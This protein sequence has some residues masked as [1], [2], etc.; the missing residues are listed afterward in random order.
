MIY[1]EIIVEWFHLKYTNSSFSLWQWIS[2][3][4]NNTQFWESN[5]CNIHQ[6]YLTQKFTYFS[7]GKIQNN[8]KIHYKFDLNY[9][10]KK[11]KNPD[12][13]LKIMSLKRRERNTHSTLLSI[14]VPQIHSSE[15]ILGI[16]KLTSKL[17]YSPHGS[18]KKD[19]TKWH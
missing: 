7:S 10:I 17:G 3:Q 13:E 9:W 2:E 15:G 6:L 18:K 19:M 16:R 11:K 8:V 1:R 14:M 4:K 5:I 12:P